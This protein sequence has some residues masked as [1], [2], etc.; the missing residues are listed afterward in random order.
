MQIPWSMVDNIKYLKFQIVNTDISSGPG[1]HWICIAQLNDGSLIVDP[2][3]PMNERL[4]DDIMIRNLMSIPSE[5]ISLN[6]CASMEKTNLF[7]QWQ[8]TI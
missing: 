6:M 1:I 4:Y 2:L 8:N 3:G 5:S 7:L